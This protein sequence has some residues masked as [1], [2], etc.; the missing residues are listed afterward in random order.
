[1]NVLLAIE[2]K[3]ATG[4]GT[5]Q[6]ALPPIE[7]QGGFALEDGTPPGTPPGD[8]QVGGS[9]S[10]TAGAMV[11]QDDWRSTNMWDDDEDT[12]QKKLEAEA[13]ARAMEEAKLNTL[14]H[15]EDEEYPYYYDEVMQQYYDPDSGLYYDPNAQEWYDP[16][17]DEQAKPEAEEG[18][19]APPPK[20]K[21]KSLGT[22]VGHM[23]GVKDRQ[24]ANLSMAKGSHGHH[25]ER[26]LG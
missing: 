18:A 11:A 12:K 7:E 26:G 9:S 4:P 8:E 17:E 1:L 25:A 22:T 5:N 2:N 14:K 13:H 21:P 6:F 3:G 23:R 10:S 20:M 24:K 19:T 15:D 16:Y